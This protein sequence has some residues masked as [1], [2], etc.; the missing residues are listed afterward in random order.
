MA[1]ISTIASDLIETKN[2]VTLTDDDNS[3]STDDVNRAFIGNVSI[4][5]ATTIGQGKLRHLV[6][7]FVTNAGSATWWS[8]LE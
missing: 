1:N 4:Q 8:K 2:D 5:D 6:G 3:I 7:K